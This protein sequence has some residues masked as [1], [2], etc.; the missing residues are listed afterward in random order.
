MA[1]LM[2]AIATGRVIN[3]RMLPR[4]LAAGVLTILLVLL[5]VAI[6]NQPFHL[7]DRTVL[8]WVGRWDFPGL[9]G[10]FDGV[11][12]LT[13]RWLGKGLALAGVAVLFLLRKIRAA[14]AL[15]VIGGIMGLVAFLSDY[16]LGELV[17][18]S[19]PLAGSSELSFP[20]G[21]VFGSTILFG[22]WGFLGIY[23]RVKKRL[24]VPL[25][26]TLGAIILAVGAA[27]ID[28]Q[29]HWPSD[30]AAGYLFG[31]L[32][33]LLFLPL[34]RLVERGRWFFP[35]KLGKAVSN[36]YADG[37]TLIVITMRDEDIGQE[38]ER[39]IGRLGT[40]KSVALPMSHR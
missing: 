12:F 18:R 32:S 15:A 21:H 1:T 5:T 39:S 29:A 30:V 11:S 34:F 10:F 40:A 3:S 17:G 36:V 37:T 19:R 35:S 9:R 23:Y 2:N 14:V 7:L 6:K 4:L 38:K 26:I 16:I 13:D 22:F 8:A 33:L 28:Q 31:F 27:R 25:L 20:S 24:L